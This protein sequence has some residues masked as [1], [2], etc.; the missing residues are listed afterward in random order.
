MPESPAHS[1]TAR[2]RSG[3]SE[4]VGNAVRHAY[5]DIAGEIDVTV[6][7]DDVGVL[8]VVADV[9]VGLDHPTAQPGLGL[10]LDLIEQLS[11]ASTIDSTSD[12]TTVTLRFARSS[13]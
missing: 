1:S 8:V 12:G 3:L 9:G 7:V 2:A 5:P 13:V 6:I 11:T 10:G 4:A